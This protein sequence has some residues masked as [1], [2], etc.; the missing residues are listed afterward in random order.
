[1]TCDVSGGNPTNVDSYRWRLYSKYYSTRLLLSEFRSQ[2]INN[3]KYDDSGEY[4]CIVQH[5]AGEVI[6]ERQIVDVSC[7]Y[8]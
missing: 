7:K 1:M 5:R 3:A 2:R 8:M 4:E 6:S